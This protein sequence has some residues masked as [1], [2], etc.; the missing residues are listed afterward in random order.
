MLY[1]IAKNIDTLAWLKSIYLRAFL[2]FIISFILVIL[3]GK[4]FIKFLKKKQNG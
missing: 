3:V 1:Y 2:G 4:P